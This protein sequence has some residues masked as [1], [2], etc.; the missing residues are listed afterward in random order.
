M[1]IKYIKAMNLKIKHFIARK[2][3]EKQLKNGICNQTFPKIFEKYL[4][5]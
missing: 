4:K 1:E 3:R 5:N 2:I